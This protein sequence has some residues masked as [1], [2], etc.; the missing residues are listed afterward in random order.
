M[1]HSYGSYFPC[2]IIP[3]SRR[4]E[5]RS[6]L[7]QNKSSQVK[8]TPFLIIS[9]IIL[10]RRIII[11]IIIINIIIIRILISSESFKV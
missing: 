7:S 4:I 10:I 9:S 5:K 11:I 1:L 6:I 8:H 3:I 2:L